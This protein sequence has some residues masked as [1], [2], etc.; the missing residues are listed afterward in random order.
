M[1][2]LNLAVHLKWLLK[3]S[4]ILNKLFTLGRYVIQMLN[5]CIFSVE[6][7]DK[8]GHRLYILLREVCVLELDEIIF[9]VYFEASTLSSKSIQK[10]LLSVLLIRLIKFSRIGALRLHRITFWINGS[11]RFIIVVCTLLKLV[12]QI[13]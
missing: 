2:A 7:H 13:L 1:R 4:L 10:L 6:K 9:V 11:F 12:I 8:H 5:D 3:L